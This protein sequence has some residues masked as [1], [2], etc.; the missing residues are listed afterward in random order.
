[1]SRRQLLREASMGFGSI[2][3]ATMLHER[4]K[5]E[6]A[7][8]PRPTHFAPKARSVI[9]LFMDGG[10]SQVDSFDPKPRL[11][12]EHGQKPKFKTDATV[13][14]AK[15]NLMASPWE[16]K[17]YGELPAPR[18]VC[19]PSLRDPVDDGVF[20]KSPQRRL[21]H[22]HRS[23][24][25]GMAQHGGVGIVRPGKPQRKPAELRRAE[26]RDHAERRRAQLRQRVSA[27]EPIGLGV[28]EQISRAE[29]TWPGGERSQI[30]GP[31]EAGY[32]Y[33][34]ERR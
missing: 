3:L 13:F 15:G 7:G 18:N 33:R 32:R 17:R 8:Q 10:V 22:P 23:R 34:I 28:H 29:V 1:M 31:L 6:S 14:N 11:Q 27:V 30:E 24:P 9:F 2:A 4:A 12:K 26:R 5:A 21:R 20:G 19:R 16:F 25:P